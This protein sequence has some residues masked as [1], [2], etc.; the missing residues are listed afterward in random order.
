MSINFEQLNQINSDLKKYPNSSL[1]IVTKNR[2]KDTIR[3]LINEGYFSFGENKVQE[4]EKKFSL[5]NNSNIKLHLIGPLQTNKVKSALRLFCTIQSLDRIKLAK[6]IS[7]Y[8]NSDKDRK[9]MTKDFYIQVNIGRESQKSGVLPEDL[10]FLYEY[11]ISNNLK[12]TGLMCIPPFEDDPRIY[13]EEMN[14]LRNTVN[15]NLKLSMGMSNDYDVAL[16]NKSDLIRVG[17]KIFK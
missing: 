16:N 4:A 5:I 15:K 13:F 17:S 9:I 6:E 2:D 7:K 3:N 8:L 12:I 14:S 1:L 11:S 10:K